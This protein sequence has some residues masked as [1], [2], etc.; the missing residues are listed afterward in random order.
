VDR[1]RITKGRNSFSQEKE[2]MRIS[3]H[4]NRNEPTRNEK[5]YQVVINLGLT[6]VFDGGG[7]VGD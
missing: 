3:E 5:S 2:K 1:T 4:E 7:L 6:R